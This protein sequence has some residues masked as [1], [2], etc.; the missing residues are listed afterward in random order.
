MK[1]SVLNLP[2]VI[3]RITER[4]PD[5]TREAILVAYER[6]EAARARQSRVAEKR[7]AQ[8]Q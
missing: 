2:I 5:V 6:F 7:R 4:F 8:R 3:N 1:G